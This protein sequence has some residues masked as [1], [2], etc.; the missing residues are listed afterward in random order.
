VSSPPESGLGTGLR[1]RVADRSDLGP[2]ACQT[3][4]PIKRF[5]YRPLIPWSILR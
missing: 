3:Y 2:V 4:E 5:N 1:Q